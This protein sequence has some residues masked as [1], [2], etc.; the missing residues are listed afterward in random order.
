MS[1]LKDSLTITKHGFERQEETFSIQKC[2][3][4]I[5]TTNFF[6]AKKRNVKIKLNSFD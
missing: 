5:L 1:D 6:Y 4:D 3:I 2:M